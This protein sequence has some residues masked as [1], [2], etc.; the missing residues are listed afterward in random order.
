MRIKNKLFLSLF[1]L[2]V[3]ASFAVSSCWWK[4]NYPNDNDKNIKVK[5]F[6]LHS[7]TNDYSITDN[8]LI[9]T[10]YLDDKMM[11]Y[12][13][14]SEIIKKL[15]GYFKL[16]IPYGNYREGIVTIKSSGSGYV[17]FN[18]IANTIEF[19]SSNVFWNLLK[20]NNNYDFNQF[21]DYEHFKVNDTK[22]KPKTLNLNEYN[23][24]LL[25]YKRNLLLPLSIMNFLFFS[26]NYYNLYFNGD[27]YLFVK[28][29]MED[30]SNL[31]KI[32]SYRDTIQT[33]EFRWDNYNFLN[34]VLDNFYGL[35]SYKK[36]TKFNSYID[37]EI[38]KNI[39]SPI[40]SE[41]TKGYATLLHKNLDELHTSMLMSSFFMKKNDELSNYSEYLSSAFRQKYQQN[42]LFLRRKFEQ[43]MVEGKLK[44][45]WYN[46]FGDTAVITFNNFKTGSKAQIESLNP[47]LYDTYFLFR[48]VMEQIKTIP[49]IKKII[50]DIS[51]NGGGSVAA[52]YKSLGFISDKQ[53]K[54][55]EED[56]TI[57]IV[58]ETGVVVDTDG[59]GKYPND[60][61]SQYKWYTLTSI[62]SFSAANSFTSIFKDS[63]FGKVIGQKTGGGACSI[64]PVVLPDGTT[65]VISN[66]ENTEINHKYEIIE[67]GIDPDVKIELNDYYE[68]EKII[69]L[70]K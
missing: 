13:S 29:M 11:P 3:I 27:K 12:V 17:K 61:Y 28:D 66:A 68:Y 6:S 52:M 19:S 10:Y 7:K 70:L 8:Q 41:N 48:R 56:Q 65:F 57:N 9:N 46:V 55:F 36:I 51:L 37:P 20:K 63:K 47:H 44:P 40:A 24:D 38:K 39:L 2:P 22:Y 1:A 5:Q 33:Q 14:L 23:F 60:A 25:F 31:D 67:A 15:N 30:D 43:K 64:L 49:E 16:I 53:I 42:M 18:H 32:S 54:S 21:I 69:P 58:K 62:N 4:D 26:H 59:D 34:L 35:K 50:V 45:N